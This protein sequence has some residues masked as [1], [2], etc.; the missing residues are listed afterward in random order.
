M[1]ISERLFDMLGNERGAQEALADYLGIAPNTVSNWKRRNTDP[2][3]KYI[4]PICD[5][6]KCSERELLAGEKKVATAKVSLPYSPEALKIA[7]MWEQLEEL[8]RDI[9]K[10]EVSKAYKELQQTDVP[11]AGRDKLA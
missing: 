5:Y 10:G 11:D 8:D 6:L 9:I 3:S 2:P 1:T 7:G 4:V